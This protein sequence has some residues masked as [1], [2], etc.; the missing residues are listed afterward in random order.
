MGTLTV[1]A[2]GSL[3]LTYKGIVCSVSLIIAA[4][5]FNYLLGPRNPQ[6]HRGPHVHLVEGGNR[7]RCF[8]RIGARPIRYASLSNPRSHDLQLRQ[9]GPGPR[10]I[11]RA[12]APATESSAAS[13]AVL[14]HRD[15]HHETRGLEVSPGSIWWLG[16]R[17]SPFKRNLFVIK[18]FYGIIF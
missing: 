12:G 18:L 14:A 15:P 16:T 1:A 6:R 7:A 8:L 10:H 13:P 3:S 4:V 9:L 2:D 11:A 17:A 5:I